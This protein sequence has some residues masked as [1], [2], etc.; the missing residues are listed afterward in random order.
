MARI[1]MEPLS[2]GAGEVIIDA[3]HEALHP[4]AGK[5]IVGMLEDKLD[6]VY[7]RLMN[8]PV[9]IDKGRAQGLSHAIAMMYNPFQPNIDLVRDEC[10]ARWE[11][12]DA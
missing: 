2:R 8:K 10:E 9:A 1:V 12:R 4:W 5:P 6:E 3:M 7:A 11:S